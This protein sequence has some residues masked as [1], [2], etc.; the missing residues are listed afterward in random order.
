MSEL[1]HTHSPVQSPAE[2]I[3]I[4]DLIRANGR[5]ILMF[6]LIG[7]LFVGVY[8]I[9]MRHT[10]Q[11]SAKIMAIETKS[12]PLA[13]IM[14]GIPAFIGGS[15]G[16]S[17]ALSMAEILSSRSNADFII[18]SCALDSL[19]QFRSL[20]RDEMQS[21]VIDMLNIDAKRTSGVILIEN[22]LQTSLFP[23]TEEQRRTAELSARICNAAIQGLDIANQE[24]STSTARKTRKYIERVLAANHLKLDTLQKSM[25]AFQTEHHV[26]TPEKQAEA[27]VSSGISIGTELAKAETE[28]RLMREQFQAHTPI[29]TALESKVASLREQYL[30]VQNGGLTS[31]DR[32]SIPVDVLPSVSMGYLNLVRDIK[33]LEQVNAYLESQRMQEAIQEERD[34]PTIQIIDA[35]VPIYKRSSPA[36]SLMLLVGFVVSAALS[37]FVLFLRRGFRGM[38]SVRSASMSD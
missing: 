36:R 8:S 38:R 20:S 19:E 26:F 13:S 33:I 14:G 25:I 22:A 15:T 6:T 29:V 23:S 30:S 3:S 10:Y 37:V 17:S 12:N 4:V 1:E 27:M 32:L 28:L 21:T 31:K 24:K 35:A 11:S 5:F 16:G 9:F 34:V 2:S 7:T 18:R